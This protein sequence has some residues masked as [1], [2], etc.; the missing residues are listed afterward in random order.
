MLRRVRGCAKGVAV[1][2]RRL[3]VLVST[4]AVAVVPAG[5]ARAT[6]PGAELAKPFVTQK[7]P[8]NVPSV[9]ECDATGSPAANVKLDCDD[10]FPNN[11]P[12]LVVD[13]A[14]PLH[15]IGSSNDYGSCCDQYYTTFDGGRTWST[16]NM[17]HRDPNITGSDPITVIDPKHKTAVHFSLN[18]HVSS[19]IPAVN[20]DV[21]ASL[22][23][24]GGLTWQ[25]PVVVG[26]GRGA[27]LFNDK[28]GAIVDTNPASPYYGR[29]YVTWT[30]F[31][32]NAKVSLRSPI[33]RSYSDDGG[34]TWAAP[35]EISGFSVT[36]C[37]FQTAGP[38][39]ECDEDQF[40]YPAVTPDGTVY[41]AFQNSQH[42]AAWEPGEQ[43]ENQYLVVR[44]TDGGATFGNPVHVADME[45]G[46]RDFPLNAD[47]RQT[48]TG[49]QMRVP[50]GGNIAADPRTG[51]LY[52]TFTDNRFGTHDVDNPVTDA[53]VFVT[54]SADGTTWS[55]PEPIRNLPAGNSDQWFPWAD[56]APDG[57]LGVIYNQR[58]GAGTHLADLAQ[59]APGSFAYTTL[60][61]A[62]SDVNQSLYFQAG[63]ADCPQC[64]LFHGD[65]LALDY[66]SDGSANAAW[67]DM[68]DVDPDTGLHEQFIYFARR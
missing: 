36:Y 64:T 1:R 2:R 52:V 15:V 61:T 67:T 63:V 48:L 29:I 65:Y 46:S 43:F 18:Y 23:T 22:S 4:L 20:G 41:V 27:A 25:V 57:T 28:D 66:G 6:E 58:N 3:V 62:Q 40:S 7:V 59:G 5:L 31:G 51:R 8:P 56:V 42:T 35:I 39:G 55:A 13:P 10:P 37:T 21:V 33:L 54:T 44:S 17:S 60:S 24:N 47:G 30:G 68:R 53:R 34:R 49:M 45:D 14:D 16:G 26:H 38:A 9:H 19:G 32:G 12:N 50:T 11:E